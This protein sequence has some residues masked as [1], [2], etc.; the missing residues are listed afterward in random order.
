VTRYTS[1]GGAIG[2]I[3]KRGL[4]WAYVVT[5]PKRV[6]APVRKLLTDACGTVEIDWDT[7][8]RTAT[9]VPYWE[10]RHI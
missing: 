9:I 6:P 8:T 1:F 5:V 7:K 4:D 10:R 3:E 2:R